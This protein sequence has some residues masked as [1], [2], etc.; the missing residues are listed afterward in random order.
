MGTITPTIWAALGQLWIGRNRPGYRPKCHNNRRKA[1]RGE[2][3]R[4]SGF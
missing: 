3:I 2:R 4:T 1:G